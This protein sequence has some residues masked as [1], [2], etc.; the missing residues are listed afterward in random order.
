M[1]LKALRN[2]FAKTGESAAQKAA[3]S[4]FWFRWRY[5]SRFSRVLCRLAAATVVVATTAV[6]VGAAATAKGVAAAAAAEKNEDDDDDPRATSVTTTTH[7]RTPPFI[8]TLS[9]GEAKKVLQK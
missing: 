2:I 7:G 6:V 5:D 4:L 1:G 9:Y 8:Y 3:L